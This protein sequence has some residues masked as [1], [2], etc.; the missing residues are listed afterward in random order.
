MPCL[1]TTHDNKSPF[2]GPVAIFS[3]TI[4][5]LPYCHRTDP[6]VLGKAIVQEAYARAPVETRHAL[7][8]PNPAVIANPVITT[9]V[10]YNS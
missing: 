8:L 7:S 5:T 4:G 6:F 1:Y 2:P 3:A 9:V 10:I